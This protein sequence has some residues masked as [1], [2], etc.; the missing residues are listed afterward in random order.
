MTRSPNFAH[1]LQFM[2]E[3]TTKDNAYSI[4]TITNSTG[5]NRETVRRLLADH[6]EWFSTVKDRYPYE[7][8]FSGNPV[9]AAALLQ[10]I[11]PVKQ[12]MAGVIASPVAE[13]KEEIKYKYGYANDELLASV[14]EKGFPRT[15]AHIIKKYAEPED[16]NRTE[17][18]NLLELLETVI[19]HVTDKLAGKD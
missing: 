11:M 4:P 6:N 19:V 12:L 14:K 13:K 7:Y 17:I 9:T 2:I 15:W 10:R 1:L 16:L 5:L 3:Y 18:V 8:Y